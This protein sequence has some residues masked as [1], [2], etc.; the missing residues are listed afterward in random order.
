MDKYIFLVKG[1]KGLYY[2]D[3]YKIFFPDSFTENKLM[4]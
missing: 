4:S 3:G 2:S 1:D